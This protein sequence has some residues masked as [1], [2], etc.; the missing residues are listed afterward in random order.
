MKN[1]KWKME[2]GLTLTHDSQVVPVGPRSAAPTI[3]KIK[4]YQLA[5]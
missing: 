2:N 5:D 4:A 3:S 1:I